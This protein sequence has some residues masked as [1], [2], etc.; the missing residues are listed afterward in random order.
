MTAAIE[1]AEA[2]QL[3]RF[4]ENFRA[5][6]LAVS[7]GPD[8]IALMA[9]MARW[10]GE[11][12]DRPRLLV[13]TVDHRLRPEAAAEAEM[14]AAAA[15]SLGLAHRTLQRPGAAPAANIQAEARTARY[16]LF[17]AAA[18]AE[19]LGAVV[20]AHHLDDQAET[21]L[22]RLGRGSGLYGLAAM[23]PDATVEG[24]RVLRPLLGVARARLAATAEAA[25]LPVVAD[26][27][28]DDARYARVRLRRLMPALAREGLT[29]ER[30][31]ATAGRL[32][33]AAAALDEIAESLLVRSGAFHPAGFAILDA[34]PLV[35]APEEIGLRA[36]SRLV[37][38]VAMAPYPPRLERLEAVYAAIR[39]TARDAG[40]LRRTL[41]G[42]VV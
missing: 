15:A 14:V 35:A 28:N 30:L 34:A 7:G 38:E 19:N 27:S 23:T 29:G 10:A 33:R 6:G 18:A 25:G 36:L 16:R 40:E 1:A 37:R 3:F 5:L 2:G 4:L 24:V 9:L 39:A 20:T 13:L 32:R 42:A 41:A 11:R 8:S 26:P 17:A 21:L 22:L 31:A 12:A